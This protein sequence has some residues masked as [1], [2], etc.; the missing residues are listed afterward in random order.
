MPSRPNKRRVAQSTPISV[1]EQVD[2][3]IA[4]IRRDH[5]VRVSRIRRRRLL[6]S[7]PP[8]THPAIIIDVSSATTPSLFTSTSAIVATIP[9]RPLPIARRPLIEG[10]SYLLDIGK[11]VIECPSC[12]ALHWIQELSSK[13]TRRHPSFSTCYADGSIHLPPLLDAP[14]YLQFLLSRTNRGTA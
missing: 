5:V 2:R 9:I 1:T 11:P 10:R 4:A 13:G 7:P 14:P 12:L 8:T 6:S 3:R